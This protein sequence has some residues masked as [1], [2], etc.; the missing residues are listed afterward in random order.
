V[1]PDVFFATARSVDLIEAVCGFEVGPG[2]KVWLIDVFENEH[3]QMLIEN[4]GA[5]EPFF[6]RDDAGA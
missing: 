3:L 5:A 4:Q 2:F 6:Q 1:L